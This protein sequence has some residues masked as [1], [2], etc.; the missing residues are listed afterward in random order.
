M[1]EVRH[2]DTKPTVQLPEIDKLF[3]FYFIVDKSMSIIKKGPSLEKI[4]SFSD[5]S[6]NAFHSIFFIIKPKSSP[7]FDFEYLKSILSG[8]VLI[9]IHGLN[10]TILKG[11]LEHR[12]KENQIV[13]FG[14]LWAEEHEKLIE[15]GLTYS[16]FPAYDAIFDIQQM[17]SVLKNEQEDLEK[18]KQELTIINHSSDLFLNLHS[19]GL[20]RKSSPSSR[21]IIGYEP[22]EMI[23]LQ[24]QDLFL[25]SEGI[26][27]KKEIAEIISTG[28]S[29]NFT[30]YILSK[31]QQK[32]GISISL[33][34][35]INNTKNTTQ[36]IGV[37][38]NINER[39]KNLEEIRNLASFP[40]ENPNPIFRIDFNGKI[41]FNNSYASSITTVI[42]EGAIFDINDIWNHILQT[43]QRENQ[44][45]V[46]L[47]ANNRNYSFKIVKRKEI[48]EYNVYGSDV[49]DRVETEQRAQDNF[50]KLNNFL[51]STND[52]YYLIYQKNK[53]KNFFTSRWP[54][55]MGFNP[56]A[57]DLWEEKRDCILDEYKKVYDDAMREFH[58][59]GSMTVRYKVKNKVSGQ[60]RWI[61]EEGKIKFDSTL[62]D[63]VISG[64]LTDITASETYRNQVRESEERF[65][66]ITES[67]PVMIWVSGQD[68][69]VSY[70]NQASRD[71]FGFDLK[72]VPDQS[73]FAEVVH[74]DHRKTAIDDWMLHLLA[75][76]KCEMQ[77]LVKN[78]HGEYRW[79]FEMA[80]PRF[81]HEQEF[82]GYIGTA[83][84]ITSERKMF[85]TLEEEKRKY[86]MISNKS[87]DIIFLINK[88]GII[89]YVSP[90]IKR[91]LGYTEKE[92]VGK[93]FFSLQADDSNISITDF[94]ENHLGTQ[95]ALS[96]QMQDNQKELKWVE[97]VYSNIS[98][99]EVGGDKLLIHV[100]D[101]NEQ[102]IAQTMVI[103]NEAKYRNLFSNM[104]LGIMEVDN[105]ERIL[106]VN[107]SFERISGYTQDELLGNRAD[108]IFLTELSEKEIYLQERRNRQHGKEGLYEIKIKK[109]NGELATWIISG[110]PTF[111]LKGKVRGSIG[112]H[113]DVTEIRDLETKILFESVQKEKELMEARLQAEE[114]QRDVIGRDLH[115]GVGQMLAYISVYFN[116]LKEK[117][118]ITTDDIDK[119]QTTIKKTIE[120]VRR[121]SRNLAPPAIKDLG[122]REAVIELIASYS[123]IP[124]PSFNLKI[125]KG[126]DPEKFMH[127]HK[128]MMFRVLQELS[129]NT[130]KYANAN[131]VDIKIEQNKK[132]MQ[133]LYQD[134]GIG[135]EMATVKKGI[136]LKSILSR[137]EFYGGDVKIK[138]K[139]GEGIEVFINLPFELKL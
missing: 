39:L 28:K 76:Q 30:T 110:A 9:G 45:T 102:Y 32:I 26:D 53:T 60:I 123:I 15:L 50:T 115:D 70:T 95:R 6:T 121:L 125:Y 105:D 106:Y 18:L 97:A 27:I 138:T 101:I 127:E 17:K 11:Q 8:F 82:L 103:E 128:I 120:E 43:K 90:S 71:F 65:Q 80:V 83:F 117:E 33:S 29:K 130:F 21:A 112:I 52:V 67:M 25:D 58:L 96:F 16:D 79:V 31:Q 3:P 44:I 66:L 68:N 84:D 69:K 94:S 108:T 113:W 114:E 86:E 129:S 7:P 122:F 139:P 20:I 133:M 61:L 24:F 98:E 4:L 92:T 62:N 38:R 77:Y 49:T 37:I 73:V 48:D 2:S 51:E 137:V 119:A 109:R 91:I 134:D 64:R 111:D 72:D 124:K 5:E 132:G 107:P 54:L 1:G 57:G 75:K 36:I 47:I 104:N 59:N 35:V 23:G 135:F 19:S 14:S 10:N 13:F 22:S 34:P 81:T 88:E 87:A 89:E 116:I 100:R 126:K 40:N 42:F 136:G 56:K 74:P 63:E 46:D 78:N 99:D 85:Y 118:T 41:L 131:K 12:V 55:L 93:F